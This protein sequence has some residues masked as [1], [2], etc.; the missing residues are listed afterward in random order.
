MQRFGPIPR[1]RQSPDPR[2]ADRDGI[3]VSE[4][5]VL[6]GDIGL[7]RDVDRRSGR[8]LKATVAGQVIGILVCVPL[9]QQPSGR[10]RR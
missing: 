10:K 1:R 7:V 6:A 4:R 2:L 5:L 3:G 8:R 9:R